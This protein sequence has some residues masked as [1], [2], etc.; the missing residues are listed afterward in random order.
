MTDIPKH[1]LLFETVSKQDSWELVSE[2]SLD[3]SRSILSR[4]FNLPGADLESQ[5]TLDFHESNLNF[6]LREHFS[7][8]KTST[9]LAIFDFT[10]QKV[11]I[12]L[13]RQLCFETF[14]KLILKHSVERS[15]YSVAIFNL[16]DL[17]KILDFALYTLFQHY[18]LYE[19]I[20]LPRTDLALTNVSRFEGRFPLV[21]NLNDGNLAD[22]NSI[23]ALSDYIE[24]PLEEDKLTDN[25][26]IEEEDPM[27][28][29][30]QYLLN[31]EMR[32][33]KLELEEK[34]KR[35]DDEF[36]SKIDGYKR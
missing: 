10:L 19:Y 30:V 8:E 29:P 36:L 4:V 6:C 26:P 2:K 31:Q 28:D 21:L 34:M 20:F 27:A 35:Q 13:N 14:K 1:F 24:K 9:L 5:I 25:K 22:P 17:K 18:S 7:A 16:D 12:A 3:K 32:A 23:S 33:I 11:R 15:P